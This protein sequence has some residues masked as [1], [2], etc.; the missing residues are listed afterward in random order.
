MKS[1][2]LARI[3][4]A[5]RNRGVYGILGVM[6]LTSSISIQAAGLCYVAHPV[7]D[8]AGKPLP[9]APLCR[10]LEKNLNEFCDEPP[11]MCGIKIAPRYAQEL[12]LPKWQ[13]IDLHGKLDAIEQLVRQRWSIRVWDEERPILEAGLAGGT[14]SLKTAEMDWFH[15]GKRGAVYRIDPGT[16]QTDNE[17]I[18]R[19]R[20]ID[21]WNGGFINSRMH[22]LPS[23]DLLS[24]AE[25]K[26]SVIDSGEA[27]DVLLYKGLPFRYAMHTLRQVNSSQEP[28]LELHVFQAAKGAD[29]GAKPVIFQEGACRFVYRARGSRK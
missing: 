19:S 14:L 13:P 8:V 18:L 22:L 20:D 24:A 26:N 10:T 4:V 3:R 25:Q 29:G 21:V 5:L 28:T 15:L 12:T 1:Y 2:L 11:L 23:T 9:I 17:E 6:A 16:C 7:N 27:G